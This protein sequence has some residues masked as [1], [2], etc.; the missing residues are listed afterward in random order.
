MSRVLGRVVAVSWP[1]SHLAVVNGYHY[2]FD[3]RFGDDFCAPGTSFQGIER[4]ARVAVRKS[5]DDRE[6]I[7]V[8][9]YFFL[10]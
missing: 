10:S 2:L 6:R 4:H 1:P 7:V 8:H 3:E 5:G 9:F